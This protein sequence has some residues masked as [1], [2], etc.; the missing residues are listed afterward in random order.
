MRIGL[1]NTLLVLVCGCSTFTADAARGTSLYSF[2]RL[3][4]SQVTLNHPPTVTL[5]PASDIYAGRRLRLLTACLQD[6]VK[7]RSKASDPDD[8]RL[9][10]AWASTGGRITGEGTQATLN[11]DG[12]PPGAYT[13]TV[14]V[15]DGGGC[16]GFDWLIVQ[17]LVCTDRDCFICFSSNLAVNQSVATV[18]A[19]RMVDFSTPG[20]VG[21]RGNY[22]RLTY[23]WTASTGAIKS[24]GAKLQLDTSG[25]TSGQ[26]VEVR[27]TVISEF[28]HCS[29]AG[30]ARVQIE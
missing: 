18:K 2:Q 1:R 12:L 5:E 20:T 6:T 26:M 17:L 9:T 14:E 28:C 11:T 13:V 29:A 19:G 8:N 25:L 3:A 23:K 21:G 27:V 15:S 22:G 24:N 7:L 4:Q 30:S 10:Y 16:V